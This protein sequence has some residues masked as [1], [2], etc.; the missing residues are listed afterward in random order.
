MA[1]G[2]TGGMGRVLAQSQSRKLP[3][4]IGNTGGSFSLALE[5]L[6]K[7]L[8]YLDEFGIVA[9]TINAAADSGPRSSAA[10]SAVTLTSVCMPGLAR[11]FPLSSRAQNSSFLPVHG[12]LAPVSLFLGQSGDQ[13]AQGS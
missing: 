3:V 5:E 7:R 8:G 9:N 1:G 12:T 4:T 11:C 6:I 13:N 2:V 10:S